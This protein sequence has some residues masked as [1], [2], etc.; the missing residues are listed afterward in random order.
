MLSE[1]QRMIVRSHDPKVVVNS[2]AAVGKTHTLTERLRFLLENGANHKKVV[3]IT[4]T[5]MAAA[6]ILSRLNNPN[7]LF[8]GT[9]HSLANYILLSAGIDTSDVIS[10]EDFDSLF[11]MVKLHPECIPEIDHLILD[12]AQDSTQLQFDFVLDYLKP[13]NFMIFGDT[14]QS[15]YQWASA[16]PEVFEGLKR[17]DGITTY[18]LNEN[19]RNGH[20]ILN[21]ARK[22]AWKAGMEDDSVAMRSEDGQV[23]ETEH[24]WEKMTEYVK[25][26]GEPGEWFVL[27]RTNA[28]IEEASRYLQQ[29]GIPFDTF[30]QSE[31]SRKELN[32]KMKENTVKVLTV[33]A[34]K[35][36]EAPFVYVMGCAPYSTEEACVCYVAATRA[37]DGLV[38]A[39]PVKKK[40]MRVRVSNWE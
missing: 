25:R 32:K 8:V 38:W 34:A 9:V 40:K 33:H 21:Y 12:E 39:K 30:K 16:V 4:F 15:L 27:C 26:F 31:L 28:Q 5:N 3:A 29:A 2:D 10:E 22:F 19:Y 37:R 14:K 11:N 23:V 18:F 17:K 24:S 7:G 20:N 13:K 35:G 1:K 36:L 6:E